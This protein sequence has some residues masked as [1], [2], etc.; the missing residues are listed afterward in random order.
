MVFPTTL[1]LLAASGPQSSPTTPVTF[2]D[3]VE[4]VAS[5]LPDG[6]SQRR[7]VAL[8][9]AEIAR[10]PVTSVAEVVA[11]LAGTGVSRRGAHGLQADTGLRGATF[12]QV[13]VLVNG[14]RVNDPQTGHFHLD[15]PFP[16]EA[17]ER[18]SVLLGPGSS[19]HGPDAFGGVVEITTGPPPGIGARVAVGEHSLVDARAVTPLGKAAWVAVSR[20]TSQ[21]Y[22]P[23]TEFAIS[24]GA[25]GWSGRAAGMDLRLDA[26]AE[27]KQFGA[28]A[29]YS[30]AFPNQR[31]RTT[32]AVGTLVAS[33]DLGAVAL[34]VR[35]GARQH[36]DVFLLDRDRPDW[37]RNRHRTRGGLVQA[38]V[39]GRAATVRWSAG[40]E[41]QRELIASSRLG[42]HDRDRSAA[43]AEAGWSGGRWGLSVQARADHVSGLGWE[44]A[45][46]L[47]LSLELGR[48]LVL[49]YHRGRSFRLPSFTDLYYA[50]PGTIGDPNLASETAW[51]DELLLRSGP[52]RWRWELA[53]FRR[54]ARD[55]IDYL[56]GDDGVYRAT[57]HAAVTTFGLEATA[58]ARE[59]GPLSALRLAATWLESDLDVDPARSRYVL[60]HPRWELSGHATALLPLQLEATA[61][62]RYRAPVNGG[63]YAVV[64]LR[65]TRALTAAL[66]LTL[67]AT[68]LLDRSYQE[69]SGVPMPGRWISL[70]LNWR[71]NGS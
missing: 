53:A 8:N 45:P 23:D 52:R 71:G 2:T 61:G 64:D 70:G 51:S 39:A 69:I 47:G 42:S 9:R 1:L 66:E 27:A 26:A 68:N 21:G 56:R 50:S 15:V 16:L 6:G 14:V 31:E 49:A 13:A 38:T 48:G 60:A 37:Y 44:G 67:E 11:W 12:E 54:V 18:I 25:L 41:V 55:V 33:R 20:T 4:V 32:S 10:L 5:R 30:Q 7:V 29:F 43:F 65:L 40:A 24:R 62:M 58:V 3:R 63:G 36:R 35:A 19:V 17:V 59:L 46:A 22:R 34:T 57:N 28:W